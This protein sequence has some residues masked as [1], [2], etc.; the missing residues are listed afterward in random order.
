MDDTL[1]KVQ[2][3]FLF[4]ANIRIKIPA[5]YSDTVFDDLFFILE[6]VNQ[7]IN[8]YTPNSYIDQINKNAGHFVETDTETV[9]LL[10][11]VIQLSD[12]FD[13][14]YDITI[15][16]LLRLWGFYNEPRIPDVSEIKAAQQRIDYHGIDFQGTKVRI[17]PDQEIITG[18]FLKA[19]AVDLLIE[20]LRHMGI[21]NAIINAGG[22][23]IYALSPNEP[24]EVA[25]EHLDGLVQLNRMAFS[26]SEQSS[27]ELTIDGRTYGHILNPKTGYPA[28]NHSIGILTDRCLVGDVLSTG[29][30]NETN[31][32]FLSKIKKLSKIY[33]VEGF[34]RDEHRT[35]ISSE[36]F[37]DFVKF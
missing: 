33:F 34:L 11:E 14:H 19:Y 12:Y 16:P 21:S 3:R 15:M 20:R 30:F 25:T 6:S 5:H 13:G 2:S 28:L 1:F 7:K 4:H 37:S 32:T 24:W 35:L 8:A 29:L 23:S 31:D 26:M 18:S 27:L 36:H 22:S 9:S 10:K 17:R